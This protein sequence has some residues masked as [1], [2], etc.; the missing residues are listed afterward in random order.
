MTTCDVLSIYEKLAGL[1]GSMAEAARNDECEDFDHLQSQC[2]IQRQLLDS[3]AVPALDGASRQ[4]KFDLLKE[5][6]ANDRAIRDATEIWP[7]Q[8]ANIMQSA[9]MASAAR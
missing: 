6:L 5:I 1:T 9:R 7:A 3:E 8:L 2:D 4:R